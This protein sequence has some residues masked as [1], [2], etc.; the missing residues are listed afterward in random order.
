MWMGTVVRLGRWGIGVGG[1]GWGDGVGWRDIAHPS[2]MFKNKML[3]LLRRELATK[4]S[5][6]NAKHA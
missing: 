1:L 2:L 4:E 5:C 6:T 3:A